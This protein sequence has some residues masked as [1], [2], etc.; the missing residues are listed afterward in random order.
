MGAGLAGRNRLAARPRR[1]AGPPVAPA[2]YH[3]EI[4]PASIRDLFR[5]PT[6]N[7]FSLS[8]VAAAPKP[9]VGRKRIETQTERNATKLPRLQEKLYAE[10]TRSILIVLQGMDT[11]GKDGTIKHVVGAMN[12]QGCRITSF[13]A[14]TKQEL[15]HHF[16]WRIRKALPSPGEVGVFNRSHYED[17]GIVRVDSLVPEKEWRG[18]YAQINRFEKGLVAGGMALV[19]IWLH[20]SFEEQRERFLKRLKDPTKRWKFNPRD[21]DKRD[22][23]DAYQEAYS[24]AII[25]C[26][27]DEAPWHIVPADA[28]WYR[29]WV[30]GQ[31]VQET[32]EEID[33]QYPEPDYD[34]KANIARLSRPERRG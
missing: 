32:F 26:S 8:E 2:T 12:P 21:L 5:A 31:L 4:V 3:P 25:R 19:K 29:N 33:P 10:R 18:R 28:R 27:N 11:S 1:V 34:L 17:V 6:G 7:G 13:K 14:P 22:Q 23:W 24:E 16:L 30:V 15:A 20:I 9:G